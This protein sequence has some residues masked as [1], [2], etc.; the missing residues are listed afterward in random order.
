MFVVIVQTILLLVHWFI[1]STWV[2]FR[3][4][5]DPPGISGLQVAVLLLAV[6]FIA[7]SLIAFRS[8]ARLARLLYKIAAVW[9]GIVNFLFL[10][11]CGCWL[12]YMVAGLAGRAW[13]GEV[14][15]GDLFARDARELVRHHQCALGAVA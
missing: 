15:G 5:P 2:R 4:V 13:T 1:Y 8:T 10:A 14:D 3:A 12:V 11:A 9:L 6:S 7:A